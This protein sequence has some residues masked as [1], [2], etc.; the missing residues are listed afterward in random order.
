M[1]CYDEDK[2]AYS[3]ADD[4]EKVKQCTSQVSFVP[5]II[6]ILV[7]RR[8]MLFGLFKYTP[9]GTFII[10]YYGNDISWIDSWFV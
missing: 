2:S 4:P 6:S 8:L 7:V 10:V 9:S 5:K 3:E 1:L